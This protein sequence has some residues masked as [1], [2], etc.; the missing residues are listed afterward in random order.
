[1]V[2]FFIQTY[3]CLETQTAKEFEDDV[4]K[5]NKL[6]SLEALSNLSFFIIPL[7]L[8]LVMTYGFLR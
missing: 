2:I 3:I 8:M 4:M 5:K 1:M 6:T 7:F